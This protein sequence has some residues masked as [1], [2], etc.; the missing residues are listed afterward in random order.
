[1]SYDFE[2]GRIFDLEEEF[3]TSGRRARD[4]SATSMSV[5]L[6]AVPVVYLDRVLRVSL[7]SVKCDCDE[8]R[9]VNSGP[10]ETGRE[11]WSND[12]SLEELL[13]QEL[14]LAR[15]RSQRM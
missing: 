4:A 12:E 15:V 1:M 2:K 9:G 11:A 13:E 14:L 7:E 6:L 5:H 8:Y 10:G 3:V